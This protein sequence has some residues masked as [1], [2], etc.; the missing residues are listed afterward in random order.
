MSLKLNLTGFEG[1]G[2]T[3]DRISKS[4]AGQGLAAAVKEA[5]E[6][7]RAAM[8]RNAPR[9]DEAPHLAD[10]IVVEE[11]YVSRDKAEVAVGPTAEYFYGEIL[12]RGNAEIEAQPWARPAVDETK[13]EALAQ[14]GEALGDRI[15]R[16]AKGGA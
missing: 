16:A 9:S 5:A 2:A 12:E 11:V 13:G 3:L 15:E 4:V 10:N 7:P 6:I 14:I 1:L 8:A